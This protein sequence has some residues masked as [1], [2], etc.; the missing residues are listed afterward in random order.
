MHWHAVIQ[1]ELVRVNVLYVV[2]GKYC[3]YRKY[4][5]IG[6]DIASTVERWEPAIQLFEKESTVHPL[7]PVILWQKL[8][9]VD[10][11]VT[12]VAEV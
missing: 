1:N 3:I 8:L 10:F 11:M 6:S 12:L 2:V 5:K 4:H 7:D 9:R